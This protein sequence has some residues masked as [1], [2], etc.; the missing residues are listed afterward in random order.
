MNN[1]TMDDKFVAIAALAV[2]VVVA[3][4]FT[5]VTIITCCLLYR[6]KRDLRVLSECPAMMW[7]K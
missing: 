1:T 3:I 5:M 7:R 2:A 6:T 4:I